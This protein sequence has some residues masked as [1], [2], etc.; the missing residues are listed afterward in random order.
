MTIEKARTIS[1]RYTTEL[2]KATKKRVAFTDLS[3]SACAFSE[4]PAEG[5][6][7]VY[8]RVSS[9][10]PSMTHNHLVGLTR[11]SSHGPPPATEAARELAKQYLSNYKSKF[12]ERFCTRGW[13]KGKDSKTIRDV[14]GKKWDW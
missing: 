11:I 2:W 10:R 3:D 13:Y 7:S 8:E 12:G 1:D 9:G 5:V 4:A 14:K 6:F